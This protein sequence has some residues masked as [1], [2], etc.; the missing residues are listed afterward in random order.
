MAIAV[1]VLLPIAYL[2]VRA[3]DRGWEPVRATLWR[4]RTLHL[5]W[6]SASLALSVSALCLVIGVAAAWLVLR[7]DLP[8]R[9]I[10]RI[11]LA[12]PL[13]LPSYVAAWAW[14]GFDADLSGRA[15]ATLVL[16]TISYPYVYLP[17]LAAMR[18]ADP[19]LEE[20]ARSLGTSRARVFVTVTLRQVRIAAIGGSLLVGLYA[21]S[22]FGAVSIMRYES[23]TQVIYRSYRASFD[24][25]PA[26]VLACV[27]VL[28]SLVPI[29]F[30]TRGGEERVAR[31]GGG[32]NRT[33]TQVRLGWARWPMTAALT[34]LLVASLGVPAWNLW[35]WTQRGRSQTDWSELAGALRSTLLLGAAAALLTVAIALPLAVLSARYPGRLSRLL[36]VSAYASHSFPG[37]VI[38]LSLVFFGVRYATPLYQR[39]PMLL[40]AYVVL[41]LSLAIG[42]VHNAVA[43]APPVLDDVARTLGRTQWGAWRSVTVPLSAPG[44]G[45]AAVLVFIAVMKELPATLLLR[46]IGTDT[47][48]TRLW[49]YTDGA[50]FAAAAPFA[51]AL[52]L[53]AAVPTAVL[54]TSRLLRQ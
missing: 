4:S 20:V 33:V 51:T 1:I 42:A 13:A 39:T 7:T 28:I 27:L 54:T 37:I 30:G 12:L 40:F 34:G 29:A 6:Q 45:A 46:P 43:Q 15:G 11:A 53:V 36:T 32:V 41:F 24:R 49:T 35:R 3:T 50:Q 25:T 2:M 47:L 52:V 16:V 18:R 31:V 44:I 26:A 23:L 48:A 38:A 9:R 5:V 8:G 10:F 22:E 19:A 14:I 17:V 21:V